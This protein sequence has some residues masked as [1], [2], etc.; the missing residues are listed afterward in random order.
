MN[1][2]IASSSKS[3]SYD[4]WQAES[5]MRTIVEAGAIR[6]DAKR[7]KNVR[8]A[9]KEKLGEMSALKALAGAAKA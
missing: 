9:A 3:D 1:D 2:A 4:K 8:R 6:K 7:M 5:D